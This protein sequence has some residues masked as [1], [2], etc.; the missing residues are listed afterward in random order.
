MGEAGPF[1]LKDFGV[2]E[3]KPHN[4]DKRP[5]PPKR[6]LTGFRQKRRQN[7]FGNGVIHQQQIIPVGCKEN[8][9]AGHDDFRLI[10]PPPDVKDPLDC[11]EKRQSV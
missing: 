8:F 4:A 1:D 9:L 7:R 6:Q 3:L 5:A 10:R 11:G 2:V